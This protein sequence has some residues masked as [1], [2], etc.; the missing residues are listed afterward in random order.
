MAL[1]LFSGH[2]SF[3]AL[4][5]RSSKVSVKRMC[6]FLGGGVWLL[7]PKE[8]S[9]IFFFVSVV[10]FLLSFPLPPHFLSHLC[11]LLSPSFLLPLF[12]LLLSP[13][14][15]LILF[16]PV[17]LF[18]ACCSLLL[19]FPPPPFSS[20][21]LCPPPFLFFLSVFV[22]LFLL[23]PLFSFF[24]L[25]PFV[26]LFFHL[27]LTSVSSCFSFP[28]SCPFFSL[29]PPVLPPCLC[30]PLFPSSFSSHWFPPPSVFLPLFSSFFLLPFF[31]LF[32]NIVLLLPS[33]LSLSFL[34]FLP[35]S[36]F[37]VSLH[38]CILSSPLS[39]LLLFLYLL[40]WPFSSPP[41]FVFIFLL[42]LS[43]SSFS[44]F[45]FWFFLLAPSL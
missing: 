11:L 33:V 32:F 8:T 31:F 10:F 5:V 6:S 22:L 43:F 44:I 34:S 35:F 30:L 4:T 15:F 37:S 12:V 38:L 17:F 29:F 18:P 1:K 16:P 40:H 9:D 23:P 36:S 19:F 26:F 20:S 3:S 28:A 14:S 39:V 42:L 7:W 13:L 24:L 45:S 21:F 27:F 41:L 2:F 25:L